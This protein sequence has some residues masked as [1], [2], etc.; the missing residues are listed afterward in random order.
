MNYKT[1]RE[2]LNDKLS[3]SELKDICFDFNIKYDNLQGQTKSE[4]IIDFLEYCRA[5]GE[6]EEINRWLEDKRPETQWL[7]NW[8]LAPSNGKERKLPETKPTPNTHQEIHDSAGVSLN[9]K[10]GNVC[11][12]DININNQ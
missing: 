3:E 11:I 2:Q 6:E 1:L 8:T 4:K 7:V 10:D 9:I 5:R 12:G